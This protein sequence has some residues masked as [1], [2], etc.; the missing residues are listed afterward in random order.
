[1]VDGAE[2]DDSDMGKRVESQNTDKIPATA[3]TSRGHSRSLK[4]SPTDTQPYPFDTEESFNLS[5]I[6][7][8]RRKR[9]K[10]VYSLYYF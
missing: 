8:K 9:V 5:N 7:F 10:N 4:T 2:R 6:D 1:M 3:K